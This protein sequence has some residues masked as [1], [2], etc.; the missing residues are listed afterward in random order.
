MDILKCTN[1]RLYILFILV[2][3]SSCN[4]FEKS[5]AAFE[6]IILTN[7][8]ENVTV[9]KASMVKYKKGS[10][11]GVSE[12]GK[13]DF[14]IIKD[15]I[16][17]EIYLTPNFDN[18]GVLT[19]DARILINDSLEYKI[20]DVVTVKDTMTKS[21]SGS[22]KQLVSNKIKSFKSN[23]RQIVN[24]GLSIKLKISDAKNIK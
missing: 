12:S 20:S 6:D 24:D 4:D 2:V 18:K 15:T 5:D 23:G 13:L 22:K 21:F 19:S 14:T 1:L 9:I 11:F 8:K 3:F 7:D 10:D 17:N 16:N